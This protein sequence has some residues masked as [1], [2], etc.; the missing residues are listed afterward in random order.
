[1]IFLEFN[2]ERPNMY[3]IPEQEY[4]EFVTVNLYFC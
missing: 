2:E 4:D 1:M 3:V